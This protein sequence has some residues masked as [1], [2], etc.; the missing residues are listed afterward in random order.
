MTH[1]MIAHHNG[2]KSTYGLHR[3]VAAGSRTNN[4]R[5]IFFYMVSDCT[6]GTLIAGA[7][8]IIYS[9]GCDSEVWKVVGGDKRRQTANR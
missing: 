2:P 3:E 4:F 6:H 7:I 9:E 1:G 8:L 5:E